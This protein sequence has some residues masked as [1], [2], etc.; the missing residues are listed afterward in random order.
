[1]PEVPPLKVNCQLCD[2]IHFR[3]LE[4]DPKGAY[5]VH[6]EKPHYMSNATCPLYRV[7]WMKQM[8]NGSKNAELLKRLM[9]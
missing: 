6:P 5:C 7:D 1:M 4:I 9:G 3:R 8:D 2:C